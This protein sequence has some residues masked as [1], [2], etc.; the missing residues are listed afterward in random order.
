VITV[1]GN[2][3]FQVF[4]IAAAITVTLAGLTIANG[5][6]LSGNWRRH[7]QPQPLTPRL[8]EDALYKWKVDSHQSSL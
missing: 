7:F 4:S 2:Q 8:R 6:N 3:M 1:S 5:P